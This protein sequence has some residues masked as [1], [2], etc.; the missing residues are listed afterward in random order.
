MQNDITELR[1]QV[2]TLNR[3][4]CLLCCLLF[5]GAIIAATSAQTIP[6][7]I[8]INHK[9]EVTQPSTIMRGV[10]HPFKIDVK[11]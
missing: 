11:K 1:N 9:M 2:R 5:A 8:T 6:S 4:V 7:T 10:T 3:V